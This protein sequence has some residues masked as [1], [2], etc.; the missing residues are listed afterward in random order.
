MPGRLKSRRRAKESDLA[1][2]E[3]SIA[4]NVALASLGFCIM[5]RAS[6]S[7]ELSER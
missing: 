3:R 6:T 1:R 4:N 2:L 7:G 5:M